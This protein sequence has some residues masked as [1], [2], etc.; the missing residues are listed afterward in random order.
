MWQV[1]PKNI[2]EVDG[3]GAQRF[4]SLILDN[5]VKCAKR[6]SNSHLGLNAMVEPDDSM[7]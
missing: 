5:S 3:F 2:Y 7:I 4:E 6:E 1:V